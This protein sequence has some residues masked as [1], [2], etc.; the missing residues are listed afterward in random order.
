L[1]KEIWS[2]F[3]KDLKVKLYN[4]D[5]GKKVI[6][7]HMENNTNRKGRN[8]ALIDFVI[9]ARIKNITTKDNLFDVTE[10]N[11]KRWNGWQDSDNNMM[12][13][14]EDIWYQDGADNE[15]GFQDITK[16]VVW[17]SNMVSIRCILFGGSLTKS[18]TS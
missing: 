14:K 4:N 6:M 11:V 2:P 12:N 5:Q 15:S 1:E 13:H 3:K 7:L 8:F 17:I 10:R 18:N 9:E 16:F